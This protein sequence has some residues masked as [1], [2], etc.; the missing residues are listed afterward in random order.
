MR[1]FC[2][3]WAPSRNCSKD[4]DCIAALELRPNGGNEAG[5][6]MDFA[7]DQ[8]LTHEPIWAARD[9][10]NFGFARYVFENEENAGIELQTIA[11]LTSRI[12]KVVI[13]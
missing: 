9:A 8:L 12:L 13:E 5:F 2:R 11:V 1:L 4:S 3:A 6:G 7:F 10:S